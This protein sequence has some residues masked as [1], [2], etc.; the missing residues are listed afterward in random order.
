[1][2][3]ER[4]PVFDPKAFLGKANGGKSISKY[5]KDQIVFSQGEP[6]D[7]VFYIEQGKIKITVVSV[8]PEHYDDG[9]FS[10]ASLDRPVVQKLL[11]DIH[12]RRTAQRRSGSPGAH[13]EADVPLSSEWSGP[14]KTGPGHATLLHALKTEGLF[15]PA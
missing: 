9:A 11:A 2:E 13:S 3:P 5:Q 8:V 12:A 15:R 10:G 14:A 7:S 4:K 1:M 6:A